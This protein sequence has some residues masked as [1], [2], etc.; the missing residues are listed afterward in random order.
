VNRKYVLTRRFEQDVA[1]L[2]KQEASQAK[3]A[4]DLYFKNPLRPSLHFKRIQ[5]TANLY[6][7]RVNLSLRIV[8]EIV[9][10]EEVEIHHLLTLGTHDRVF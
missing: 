7:M 2:Q 5:G 6:E 10:K 1:R 9:R 3:K 4:L 8:V